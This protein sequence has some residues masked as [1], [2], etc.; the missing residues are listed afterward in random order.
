MNFF[1]CILDPPNDLNGQNKSIKSTN[2]NTDDSQVNNEKDNNG[3]KLRKMV[4]KHRNGRQ[5]EPSYQRYGKIYY[6]YNCT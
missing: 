3:D 2:I 6:Y 4:K 1:L 5:G